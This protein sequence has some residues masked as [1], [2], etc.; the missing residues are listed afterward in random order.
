MDSNPLRLFCRLIVGIP[1]LSLLSN[2]YVFLWMKLSIYGCMMTSRPSPLSQ[3][4]AASGNRTSA[5]PPQR[6]AAAGTARPSDEY[7]SL[8]PYSFSGVLQNV[9]E[10]TLS[11][12]EKTLNPKP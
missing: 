12:T 10:H 5:S 11:E 3:R 4:G 8:A 2:F 9:Y 7:R 1:D 6:M